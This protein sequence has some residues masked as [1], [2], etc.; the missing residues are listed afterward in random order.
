MKT[1]Q[2]NGLD[3]EQSMI[4]HERWTN[5]ILRAL[6]EL[7]CASVSGLDRHGYLGADSVVHTSFISPKATSIPPPAPRTAR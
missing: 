3:F 4:E 7:R 2:Q 5:A 1:L 6:H